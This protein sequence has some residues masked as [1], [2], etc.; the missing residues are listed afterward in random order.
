MD[1]ADTRLGHGTPICDIFSRTTSGIKG[2]FLEALPPPQGLYAWDITMKWKNGEPQSA[3]L[4]YMLQQ[5]WG[6]FSALL[7]LYYIKSFTHIL[8]N[9]YIYTVAWSELSLRLDCSVN[10]TNPHAIWPVSISSTCPSPIATNTW[11]SPHIEINLVGTN[12][13]F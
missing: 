12:C 6:Y 9:Y 13:G 10:F 4:P 1:N 3:A 11:I 2:K 7:R 5:A 8:D